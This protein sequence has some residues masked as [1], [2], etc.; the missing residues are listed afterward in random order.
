MKDPDLL[1]LGQG[2]LQEFVPLSEVGELLHSY[3]EYGQLSGLKGC[4]EELVCPEP[5]FN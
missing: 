4:D 5:G 3:D 1:V 2:A